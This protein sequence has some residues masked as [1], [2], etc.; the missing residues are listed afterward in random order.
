MEWVVTLPG[1]PPGVTA[2]ELESAL[3]GMGLDVGSQ[4][5]SIA[6]GVAIFRPPDPEAAA[7][8]LSGAALRGQ[9]L[10]CELIQR[11]IPRRRI[12]R[13]VIARN[14]PRNTTLEQ[15]ESLLANYGYT[16]RRWSL[17]RL[18]G[19]RCD[20]FYVRFDTEEEARE[21]IGKVSGAALKGRPVRLHVAH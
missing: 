15:V 7:Q 19:E 5:V 3:V 13:A 10:I 4:G 17:L 18:A 6:N 16:R 11:P 21:F 9:P 20:G 2:P 8:A 14:L 1:L 12:L